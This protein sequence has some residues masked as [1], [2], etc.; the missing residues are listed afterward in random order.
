MTLRNTGLFHGWLILMSTLSLNTNAA[1]HPRLYFT[2]QEQARL[3]DLRSTGVH[4]HIWKNM[5][6]SADWCV[7]KTPRKKWIAPL[8]DDPIYENLYD[9]FYGMMHDMAVMEHLAFTYAYS[10]DPRY[11]QAGRNWAL[12]CAR[13]WGKEAGSEP[14]SSKAYAVS[15]LLKGLAVSY[16]LLYD[17]LSEAE[18]K[19]LRGTMVRNMR[20]Y[21]Q[22]YLQN[23][24]MG[25]M[26]QGSHHAT[27]ETTS[28]GVLALALLGEEPEAKDWLELMVKK[29]EHLMPKA[30]HPSGVHPEGQSFWASTMQYR[31][32][33]LDPLRR[34]TGRDLFKEFASNRD[35]RFAM[36]VVA[37]PRRGEYDED[38]ET[39]LLQPS[40][41]Q[42]NYSSPVLLALARECRRPIYQHLALWDTTLGAINKSRY[43][44]RHR[45]QML[46]AFGGYAYAWYDP[47]VPPQIEDN[48]PLSFEFPELNEFA[49]RASYE[50][51]AIAFA[52]DRGRV[53]IHAGGQAVFVESYEWTETPEPVKDVTLLDSKTNAVLRSAEQSVE[54]NR[55]RTLTLQR[56]TEKELRF[57][58]HGTPQRHGNSLR[59]P[60]GTTLTVLK[61]SIFSFAPH[62][63]CANKVTGMGKLDLS[64]YDPAPM[65]HPLIVAKPSDKELEI[66]IETR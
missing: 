35:G 11:F 6:A 65:K 17:R 62:G 34:L 2:P 64:P 25:T 27:V 47:T 21:Y 24:V 22:W 36:A 28:F 26:E 14:D 1:E 53:V 30:I 58:C 52:M 29:T 16:D 15:R 3:R 33:F 50:L 9:R 54:L 38:H 59:W 23:P 57:W 20:K 66:R 60:T 43:I 45:E 18:R 12:S 51:G 32:F 8:A 56:K 4:A 31:L 7:T 42:L 10:G 48:L 61:G 44:T 55:P 13:V 5:A 19:E 40:Y 37:A 63:Y 41:A 39:A 49:L 46:F